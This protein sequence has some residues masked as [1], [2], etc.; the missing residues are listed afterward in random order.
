MTYGIV[1][2][3]TTYD[4]LCHLATFLCHLSKRIFNKMFIFLALVGIRVFGRLLI[5]IVASHFF[6]ARLCLFRIPLLF[7]SIHKQMFIYIYMYIYLNIIVYLAGYL[8]SQLAAIIYVYIYVRILWQLVYIYI[9][10]YI[11]AASCECS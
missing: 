1:Y 8:H 11:M 10:T 9:Y 5:T 4:W 2:R 3:A 7:V 6:T